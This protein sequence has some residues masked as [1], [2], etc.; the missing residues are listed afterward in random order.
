MTA[1]IGSL[2]TTTTVKIIM[3]SDLHVDHL[4]IRFTIT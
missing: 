3:S 4:V 2:Q 1:K